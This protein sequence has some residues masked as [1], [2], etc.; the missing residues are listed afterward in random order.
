MPIKITVTALHCV[1]DVPVY[2]IVVH[3]APRKLIIFMAVVQSV[4]CL[5]SSFIKKDSTDCLWRYL[6]L[7]QVRHTPIPSWVAIYRALQW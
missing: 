3:C 1:K 5:E 4:Q 2:C 6:A 7:I